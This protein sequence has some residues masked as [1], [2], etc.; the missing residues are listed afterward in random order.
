MTEFEKRLSKA[1]ERGEQAR[2]ERQR[3]KA[4][5][6]LSEEEFRRLHNQYRLELSDYIEGC[7]SQLP[8][9]FPGFTYQTVV[10]D[11]GWGAKCSRD[12]VQ[13]GGGR[14]DNLFSRLEMLV[15]PFASYFV[16]ELIAKGTIRNKEVFSRKQFQ[17]LGEA[18]LDSFR[19]LID[20]WVLEYAELYAAKG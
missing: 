15:R 10:G 1:I 8:N 4:S 18:D 20:L 17:K 2:D 12:D 5:E 9:H 6:S 3:A 19:E 7:L 13:L 11:D 14:R 16:L